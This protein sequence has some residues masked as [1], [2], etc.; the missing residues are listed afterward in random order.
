MRDFERRNFPTP[1]R[2]ITYWTELLFGVV[3]LGVALVGSG[4]NVGPI[5]QAVGYLM[6]I[7]ALAHALYLVIRRRTDKRIMIILEAM[8]SAEDA[9]KR[10]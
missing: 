6:G 10:N 9:A 8:L 5:G 3:F 7:G 2:E 4:M 1:L